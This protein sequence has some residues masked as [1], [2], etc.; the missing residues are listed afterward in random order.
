MCGIA[1]F[2]AAPRA[3]EATA[4]DATRRMTDHMRPRGPDAGGVW[5]SERVALGH[6]RRLFLPSELPA[7]LGADMAREGL[8][9][10]DGFP[11]GMT[12]AQARDGAAAVGPL[13][14]TL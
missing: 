6:R 11:P 3:S 13:E 14:S 4:L 10:L 9:R 5:G 12:S 1:G 2:I 8:A 7:L